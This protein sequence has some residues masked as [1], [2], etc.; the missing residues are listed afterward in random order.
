MIKIGWTKVKFE[1]LQV[2]KD[3]SFGAGIIYQKKYSG[4]G[5]NSIRAVITRA[6]PTAANIALLL[7][8]DSIPSAE[9]VCI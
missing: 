7:N 1:T 8:E 5:A 9:S 2:S 3:Y 4:S 6:A